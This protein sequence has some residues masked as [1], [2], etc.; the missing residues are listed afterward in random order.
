MNEFILNIPLHGT[1]VVSF[2]ALTVGVHFFSEQLKKSNYRIPHFFRW[3]VIFGITIL[4][5]LPQ[6]YLF[7]A[8]D[9]DVKKAINCIN[10]TKN[11]RLKN[12]LKRELNRDNVREYK[13][14]RVV[15][16]CYADKNDA[17][18]RQKRNEQSKSLV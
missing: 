2:L 13:V 12:Y 7:S 14:D 11:I 9:S 5:S 18:L 6:E 10:E 17:E 15:R 16:Q 4:I 8:S 1:L 3:L